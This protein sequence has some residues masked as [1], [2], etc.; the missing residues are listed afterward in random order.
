MNL[1]YRVLPVGLSVTSPMR[2]TV[3]PLYEAH[4]KAF[5]MLSQPWSLVTPPASAFSP[6]IVT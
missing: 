2:N 3:S 4:L 5:S 1:W 6:L